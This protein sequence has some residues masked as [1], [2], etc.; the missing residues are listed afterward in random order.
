MRSEVGGQACRG[1][2]CHWLWE[3]VRAVG[4]VARGELV[5]G[6]QVADGLAALERELI[7]HPIEGWT[8][9]EVS[10]CDTQVEVHGR[11]QQR[12]QTH[13]LRAPMVLDG[14]DDGDPA[15]PSTSEWAT[16]VRWLLDEALSTGVLVWGVRAEVTRG[17]PVIDVSTEAGRSPRDWSIAVGMPEPLGVAR[18]L[19]AWWA[20]RGRRSGVVLGDPSGAGTNRRPALEAM[21]MPGELVEVVRL[22]DDRQAP[23]LQLG[24]AI[25]TCQQPGVAT[26]AHLDTEPG[27]PAEAVDD[28]LRTV[29]AVVAD[30]GY[31]WL[32]ADL[33]DTVRARLA[34]APTPGSARIDLTRLP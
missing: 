30:T 4:H 10:G 1:A 31:R 19:R 3:S 26:L 34:L 12:I 20:L 13:R 6:D 28:L 9:L 5:V 18:S 22:H 24:C 15:S 16:S 33:D 23:W 14:P 25:L 21:T 8:V 2:P 29:V 17:V 7:E 32:D 11:W 27:L